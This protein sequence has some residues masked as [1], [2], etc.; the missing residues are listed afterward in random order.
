M[1][2]IPATRMWD[3]MDSLLHPPD[4][5]I[6]LGIRDGSHPDERSHDHDSRND[7][8]RDPTYCFHFGLPSMSGS[9][10]SGA[11]YR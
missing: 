5:Q 2:P 6:A 8:Y 1:L 11:K 4:L 3:V 10:S 7:A 9:T